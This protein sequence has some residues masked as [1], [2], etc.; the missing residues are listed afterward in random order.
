MLLKHFSLF[1]KLNSAQ[2][3]WDQLRDSSS[4]IHYFIPTD[5]SSYLK[6][7]ER[8]NYSFYVNEINRYCVDQGIT[9]ILSLGAGRCGLE[10]YLQTLTNLDVEVTDSSD[11]IL[12]IK[13][14]NIFSNAY[15]LDVLQNPHRL[16]VDSNT[17]V[18]LSRIDTEFDRVNFGLLFSLLHSR[19]AK[20][21]AVIPAE[22]ISIKFFISEI[23]IILKSFLKR[24]KRVFCGF[25]RTKKEFISTWEKYYNLDSDFSSKKIFYL[26][27]CR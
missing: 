3:D 4:E 6:L 15:T 27:K 25:A 7:V 13:S 9:K 11:S 18:L 22:L 20:Y 23:K 8:M 1:N 12:R 19:N 21:V 24:R 17:L 2:I 14:F 16:V 10:F 5:K 26:K